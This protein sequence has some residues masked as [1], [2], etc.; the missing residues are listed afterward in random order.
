[1]SIP[2]IPDYISPIVGYRVWNWDAIGL[3]SLNGERWFPDR[4]LASK[5]PRADHE[6]PTDDCSCGV[7][8][9]KNYQH[10]RKIADIK[11]RVHGEVYLWGTVVEHK[12][13]YRAQ[14]AYPKSLVLPPIIDPRLD[15]SGLEPLMVYGADSGKWT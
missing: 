12:L 5:C 15:P 11:C 2:A 9:A 13:G 3:W 6:P 14:Y 8:A 1:M 4:A 10:L 7:Y